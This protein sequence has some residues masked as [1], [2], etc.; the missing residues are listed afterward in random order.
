VVVTALEADTGQTVFLLLA[1]K[2]TVAAIKLRGVVPAGGRDFR[3]VR[4]FTVVAE[5][6][7]FGILLA[8][9]IQAELTVATWVFITVFAALGVLALAVAADLAVVAIIVGGA[10]LTSAVDTNAPVAVLVLAALCLTGAVAADAV[11]AGTIIVPFALD[12]CA[13]LRL[14]VKAALQTIATA[15][16]QLLAARDGLGLITPVTNSAAAPIGVI[17]AI[18]ISVVVAAGFALVASAL[19]DAAPFAI[20]VIA[21]TRAIGIDAALLAAPIWEA[22]LGVDFTETPAADIP[23][24]RILALAPLVAVATWPKMLAMTVI[25]AFGTWRPVFAV[26]AL[27]L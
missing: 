22:L 3:Q 8:P 20:A 19:A 15:A 13:V 18:S 10:V 26:G 9:A 25:K 12:A 6:A 2:E 14:V 21:G 23:F 11:V 4:R 5:C 16:T 27:C 7:V 17:G 24:A 1:A